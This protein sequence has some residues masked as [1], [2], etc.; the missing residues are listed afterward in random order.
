M[1]L[2]GILDW[3]AGDGRY[4][5]LY[6]CMGHDHFWIAVTVV[7]DL[8]VAA[9]Y[10]L[11]AHHWWKNER[12]LP[13]IPAKRALTNMR[14]IFVFCGICGYV[15]IPVKMIWPA[16]RLYDLVML[17]LLYF[18]WRYAL[19]AKNMKVVYAELGRNVEL[20]EELKRSREESRRKSF[21]LNAI[22]HDLRT[23]LN[24]LVL[25]ANL[26]EVGTASSDAGTVRAAV[27]EMKTSAR[28][29]AELL[30]SFL[31]YAR[32]DWAED[33]GNQLAPVDLGATL[34]KVASSFEAAASD[35]GLYLRVAAPTDLV[36]DS[37][38]LKLERILGNLI[39]NAIKFTDAGGVRLDVER[40]PAAVQVHVL[41]TGRGISP[42]DQGRLFEEFYQV[43]N[44]ERD[45]RKGF[46]LGLTIAKRLAVQ[47]GGDVQV[48]S[49]PGR[50][51][52]FSL[53]LPR[54]RAVDA[55]TPAADA[56]SGVIAAP[57]SQRE[58]AAAAAVGS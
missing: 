51:S 49:A 12:T 16:W 54:A 55:T 58:T 15:F 39:G 44:D 41:D 47:L 50:G 6:H 27:A 11:I 22:S 53:I 52:R 36:V 7:L 34:R 24:S 37:D 33:E 20:T 3:F 56:D 46:G 26:A 40:S 10:V 25:Q 13:P 28:A 38:R 45:R 21:F 43:R 1:N 35:K 31:E 17:A 42:Q 29:A 48:D 30:D 32:L 18:T 4:M 14:N 8:A 5:T 57:P 2:G 9:G 19:N 23:P